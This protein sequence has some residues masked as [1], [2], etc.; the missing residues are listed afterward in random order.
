MSKVA[1]ADDRDPAS[2]RAYFWSVS[3]R[4]LADAMA[5]LGAYFQPTPAGD[6]RAEDGEKLWLI[7]GT[8]PVCVIATMPDT[9]SVDEVEMLA[10]LETLRGRWKVEWLDEK[11]N[12]VREYDSDNPPSE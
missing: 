3:A 4:E 5:D 6:L 7:T 10:L 8:S 11:G 2:Y 1:T 9:D 12:V